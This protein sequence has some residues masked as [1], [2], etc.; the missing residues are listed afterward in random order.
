MKIGN[1]WLKISPKIPFAGRNQVK[2]SP[3]IKRNAQA[4][5]KAGKKFKEILKKGLT[6][7]KISGIFEVL[8]KRGAAK[9][10]VVTTT[11]AT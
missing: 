8:Q 11:T 6:W 3:C 9:N 2:L 4:V 7:G 10:P 5:K 1:Y